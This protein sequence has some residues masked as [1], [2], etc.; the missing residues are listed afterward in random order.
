MFPPS[1]RDVS[2]L[3]LSLLVP[4]PPHHAF[5]NKRDDQLPSPLIVCV[6]AHKQGKDP[7]PDHFRSYKVM[8]QDN[9]GVHIYSGIP[10]KAFYLAAVAFGGYSWERAGRIWWAALRSGQIPPR[11]KFVQFADVTIDTAE[12]LYGEDAARIVSKA[13]SDVGVARKTFA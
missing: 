1:F 5:Y 3:S 8:T 12:E 10:N 9:G 11:C 4:T 6:I 2:P 7:Q 13:W